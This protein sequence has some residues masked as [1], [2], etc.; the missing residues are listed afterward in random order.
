[1]CVCVCQGG[2]IN[3]SLQTDTVG[4]RLHLKKPLSSTMRASR[5]KVLTPELSSHHLSPLLDP[6]IHSINTSLK[7]YFHCNL[8][9]VMGLWVFGLITVICLTQQWRW[10]A[11]LFM[12][13]T[14]ILKFAD[15]SVRL[16]KTMSVTFIKWQPQNGSERW[17]KFKGTR[18]Q[19]YMS[20]L[21]YLSRRQ[22]CSLWK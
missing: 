17:L 16:S 9:I 4:R 3:S 11:H 1:M 19:F 14:C 7:F 12:W 21:T 20:K 5:G 13:L 8:F 15:A 22:L 6:S 2:V 10:G 18:H